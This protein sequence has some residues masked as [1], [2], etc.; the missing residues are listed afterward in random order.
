MI[1]QLLIFIALFSIVY[2]ISDRKSSEGFGSIYECRVSETEKCSLRSLK[3]PAQS[4]SS[5][6]VYPGGT[7]KCIFGTDFGFQVFPGNSD[8]LLLYFQGGGLCYSQST[9]SSQFCSSTSTASPATGLFDQT[10]STNPFADYTIIQGLYCSGDVWAGNVTQSY[11]SSGSPVTQYGL[12]NAQAIVS[13]ILDQQSSGALSSTFVNLVVMGCS[14]GALGT[15]I[16]A[17]SVLSQLK[18][19]H[20]AVVPDSYAA[21]F[22]SGSQGKLL[23]S[24]NFCSWEHLPSELA[25]S[26]AAQT[27]SFQSINAYSQSSFANVAF[28]FI[29]SKDDDVQM[30]LYSQ[31]GVNYGLNSTITDSEFYADVNDIFGGYNSNKNFV[32][33]LVDGQTHCYTNG[34][35]VYTAD[36]WSSS[37][38]SQ[39]TDETMI[40][41]LTRL[42]LSSGDAISSLCVGSLVSSPLSADLTYCSTNVDPKTFTSP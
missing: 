40:A 14:A 41:W 38:S 12:V 22:P 4:G 28:G 37:G 5:T 18:W 13:W 2:S 39:N 7:T 23:A 9:T 42:P 15:Q 24:Y 10:K 19:T 25:S 11:T 34:G 1:S 26:C 8:K 3:S 27:I 29:Q 30:S 17:S 20:A 21:V 36:G 35:V 32:S 31:V 33:Y 16:W 6:I